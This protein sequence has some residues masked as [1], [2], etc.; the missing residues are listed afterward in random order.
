MA[1]QEKKEWKHCSLPRQGAARA[2]T[3]LQLLMGALTGAELEPE[4]RNGAHFTGEVL[5]IGFHREQG[6]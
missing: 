5:G 1:F 3:S 6:S 4:D 2:K